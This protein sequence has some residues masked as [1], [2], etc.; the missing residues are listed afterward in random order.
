MAQRHSRD[1]NSSSTQS[2]GFGSFIVLLVVAALGAAIVIARPWTWGQTAANPTTKPAGEEEGIKAC[3]LKMPDH[4]THSDNGGPPGMVWIPGGTFAMGDSR[5]DGFEWERPVHPV[6]IDGFYMDIYEVTNA[7][8]Q[9]FVDATG[10]VTTAEKVPDL[11]EIM[12]QLPPGTPPPPKD[13]LKAGSLVFR[14]TR[15]PVPTDG[16][17]WF[18]W[19]EFVGGANWQHPT[20]PGSDIKGKEYYPVVH[21]CWDDAVAYCKWAGKRLPT[22]AEWE[23]AARGGLDKK[24]YTWGDDPFDPKKSHANIWQGKFP[25]ENSLED[26]YDTAAP[27]GQY[28]PNNYGLYD[29]AGN[30]WEWASDWF[31]PLTYGEQA[32]GGK[33]AVN[34]QGPDQSVDPDGAG[35]PKRSIR[36]GSFLCSDSY[37]SS[38]RPSARMHTSPD[39]GTNHQGLRTV[40]TKAQWEEAK[41]KRLATTRPTS[42]AVPA[43]SPSK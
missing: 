20:G 2:G 5:G 11:R 30:V 15:G 24:P 43:T 21:I 31:S 28:K 3:C 33:T 19:W 7:Q 36:G 34:P 26:G 10:F 27:V 32:A 1:N 23:F 29:M 25:Y 18:Q 39:S 12:K 9:A 17:N 41:A 35:V 16:S 6:T 13:S 4:F 8:W 38:Y 22:E 37:C 14:K 42:A 40:M